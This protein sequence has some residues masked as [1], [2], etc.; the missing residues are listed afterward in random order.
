MNPDKISEAIDLIA[1]LDDRELNYIIGLCLEGERIDVIALTGAYAKKL[2]DFKHDAEHDIWRV[3]EAGISLAEKVIPKIG[4]I[5]SQQQREVAL[6]QARTLF[7]A[8]GWEGTEYGNR[9]RKSVDTSE[10]DES[11]YKRAWGLRTKGDKLNDN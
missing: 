7:K 9:I 1:R 11:W 4:A 6:A 8:G 3:S 5:K 2:Q 10:I